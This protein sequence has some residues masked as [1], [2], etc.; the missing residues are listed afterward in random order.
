MFTISR[1][2]SILILIRK[3]S[4]MYRLYFSF[5]KVSDMLVVPLQRGIPQP[6]FRHAQIVSII[7]SALAIIQAILAELIAARGTEVRKNKILTITFHIQG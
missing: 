6:S 2:Y 3:S 4:L 7:K 1:D 5:Q